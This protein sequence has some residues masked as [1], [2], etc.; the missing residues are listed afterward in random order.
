[1]VPPSAAPKIHPALL[2]LEAAPIDDELETES[3]RLAVE[4][5]REE[6]RQGHVLTH[7]EVRRQWLRLRL[8][9]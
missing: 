2:A 9:L 6:V 5:A 7:E 8:P 4:Q 1:M 3:E